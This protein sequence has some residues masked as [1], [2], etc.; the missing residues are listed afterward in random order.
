[1]TEEVL[2]GENVEEEGGGQ[3]WV[4]RR[5]AVFGEGEKEEDD[6]GGQ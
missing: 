1:M 5:R 2:K 6:F 3:G 4:R